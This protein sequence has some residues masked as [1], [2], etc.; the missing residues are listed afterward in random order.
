MA[1][2]IRI[3]IVDDHPVV[4]D[5]LKGMLAGLPTE[6]W[7]GDDSQSRFVQFS[8]EKKFFCLDMPLQTLYRAEAEEILRAPVF[9]RVLFARSH[10]SGL[11]Q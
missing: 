3:L 7:R 4:R 6:G 1:E 11:S 5:G 10:H 8:F 9:F 2:R